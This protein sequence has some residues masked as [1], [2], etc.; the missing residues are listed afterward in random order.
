MEKMT[1]KWA[2]KA[3]EINVFRLTLE[4]AFIAL[5]C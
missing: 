5:N 4:K 2:K 3:S 1:A